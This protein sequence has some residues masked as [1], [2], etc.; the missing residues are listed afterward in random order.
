MQLKDCSQAPK[1]RPVAARCP[2]PAR[3]LTC[4]S[5]GAPHFPPQLARQVARRAN[6]ANGGGAPTDLVRRPRC[7]HAAGHAPSVLAGPLAWDQRATACSSSARLALGLCDS[8]AAPGGSAAARPL[9]APARC[10]L[11]CCAGVAARWALVTPWGRLCAGRPGQAAGAWQGQLGGQ[12]A[13]AA[14]AG[15]GWGN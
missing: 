14:L 12:R 4:C 15:L 1:R 7:Q 6:R 10:C 8:W 5:C 13:A 11:I 3:R 2:A 9:G